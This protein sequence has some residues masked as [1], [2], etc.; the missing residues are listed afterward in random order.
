M[1]RQNLND[2][3]I[4]SLFCSVVGADSGHGSKPEPYG[5]LH[6][7]DV[8]GL[9]PK[10]SIMVGD[11]IADYSA[12]LAAGCQDFICVAETYELRPHVDIQPEHVISSLMGLPPLLRTLA[13]G[14]HI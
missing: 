14:P 8:A 2:L 9:E 6:C 11:T 4:S 13:D 10:D 7:C 1:A 12:A 5:L 3:G